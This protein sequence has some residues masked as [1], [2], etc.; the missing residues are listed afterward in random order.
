MASMSS[1]PVVATPNR[2]GDAGAEGEEPARAVAGL[3]DGVGSLP[4]SK[5]G[6][7]VG[8]PAG[9]PTGPT[10]NRPDWLAG[11]APCA[12]LRFAKH[13][14]DLG[15]R[16]VRIVGRRGWGSGRHGGGIDGGKRLKRRGACGR[17][18]A[19][20]HRNTADAVEEVPAKLN[21]TEAGAGHGA[22]LKL[23]GA[24]AVAPCNT[25]G[26]LEK[27]PAKVG[28]LK[29]NGTEAG[30]GHAAAL[31]L[32][33][34]G[35]G[36]RALDAAAGA[37]EN[38]ALDDAGA[39]TTPVVAAG[40]ATEGR[41]AAAAGEGMVGAMGALPVAILEMAKPHATGTKP[42]EPKAAAGAPNEPPPLIPSPLT[43]DPRP[44]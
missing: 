14:G 43:P 5:R 15:A 22:A 3:G 29:R 32:N 34:A 24:E 17:A 25:A 12:L 21:G 27:V 13:H 11:V 37:P 20:L 16:L 36:A 6:A 4:M 1:L 41:V 18:G 23:N 28:S 10:T 38:T 35:A 40:A 2:N 8:L 9:V 30:A 7:A 44:L 33:G 31:K 26:A 39:Q 42:G 19:R